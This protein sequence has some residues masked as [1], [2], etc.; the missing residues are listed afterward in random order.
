MSFASK[1]ESGELFR[2]WSSLLY[3]TEGYE[4]PRSPCVGMILGY[5]SFKATGIG[6]WVRTLNLK[7]KKA[8][9]L[10]KGSNSTFKS[11][12]CTCNECKWYLSIGRKSTSP[13]A[14]W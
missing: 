14:A 6:T 9:E 5:G 11:W 1:K 13:E 10:R 7:L 8:V 2:D 3:T 4:N 12:K